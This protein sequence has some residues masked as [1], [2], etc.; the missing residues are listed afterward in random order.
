MGK[1]LKIYLFFTSLFFLLP[2]FSR[3]IAEIYFEPNFDDE[4]WIGLVINIVL[5][6]IVALIIFALIK[7]DKIPALKIADF[8]YLGFGLVS[9]VII[10]FYTY[11]RQLDI[12]QVMTIYL[13]VIFISIAYMF[14]IDKK[15]FNYEIWILALLY[16]AV[17]LI[18]FEYLR[19]TL[20]NNPYPYHMNAFFTRIFYYII[21]LVTIILT[22]IKIRTYKVIDTFTIIFITITTLMIL[23]NFE[24]FESESKFILTLLLVAPF[25]IIIDFIV[26]AI[27][28]KFTLYKVAFYLRV[29]TIFLTILMYSETDYFTQQ[30]AQFMHHDFYE[31]IMF[32][33]IVIIA[34][35]IEYLIPK[36][37]HL[38]D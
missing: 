27:Y 8:K 30:T 14:I 19:Y 26:S 17:D 38:E 33:Y 22:V 35:L 9:N 11:Q 12:E 10:F 31:M 24:A 6:G 32:I 23:V 2:S 16:F 20:N 1:V 25:V 21:P 4:A 34:N 36:K 5:I 18:H 29:G 15:K 13:A 3:G 7:K 37:K 28:K